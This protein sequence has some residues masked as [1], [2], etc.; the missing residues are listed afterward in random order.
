M[1]TDSGLP[2]GRTAIFSANTGPHAGTL[3]V[4]LVPRGDRPISDV[5]ASER[6]R[7]EIQGALP[8]AQLYFFVGGIVK[9]LLNFGSA[10]PIAVL[11][12]GSRREPGAPYARAVHA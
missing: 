8:G 11:I 1:S 2:V 12:P 6:L 7:S 10:A 3:Q 9:R 4:N 5:V